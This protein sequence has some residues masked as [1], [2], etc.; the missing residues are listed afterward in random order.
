LSCCQTSFVY[1]IGG[2]LARRVKSV[3]EELLLFRY[4]DENDLKGQKTA[5]ALNEKDCRGVVITIA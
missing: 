3:K 4:H 1:T 5:F 2:K